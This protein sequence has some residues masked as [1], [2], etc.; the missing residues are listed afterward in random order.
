MVRFIGR[1]RVAEI[2]L[3]REELARK[4]RAL[5]AAGKRVVFTNGCFDIL[6]VGHVRYLEGA[7]AEGDALVLALNS[8]ESI[9]RL[10]G[11][12]RPLLPLEDRLVILSA[13]RMVDLVTA[14]DEDTVTPLLLALRPDVHAKGTD[15]TV[16]TVPEKDTVASYGG[17]VAVVGD[18]KN[19]ASRDLIR[20][21]VRRFG[22]P[23]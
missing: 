12:E 7:R 2:V 19:H 5:Q 18:P 21:I 6:H 11:P 15:Y 3:D 9:R 8:D 10:K 16:G 23:A 4:V 22:P 14:F 20:E 13:F 1:F 17:R